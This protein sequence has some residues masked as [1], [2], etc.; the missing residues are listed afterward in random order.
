MKMQKGDLNLKADNYLT[1]SVE[2]YQD[3]SIKVQST[4]LF[5]IKK[6][7]HALKK[8]FG[9]G[10]IFQYGGVEPQDVTKIG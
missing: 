5:P 10:K 2:K 3:R 8:F 9:H 7:D 6:W 4:R 1:N